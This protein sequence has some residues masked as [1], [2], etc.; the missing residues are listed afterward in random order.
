M[1]A[2][3]EG[4][5]GMRATVEIDEKLFEDARKLSR[6]RTKKEV[7]NLSLREYV[8]RKRL[9]H[10]LGLYGGSPIDLTSEELERVRDDES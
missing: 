3:P 6:A 8:R 4:R 10:L 1:T 2:Q 7:I 5:E 9:E